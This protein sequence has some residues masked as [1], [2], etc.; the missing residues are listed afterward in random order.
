MTTRIFSSILVLAAG[1]FSASALQAQNCS[2]N[3]VWACRYDQCG[4]QEC[5]CV[6]V[7]QAA[8]WTA[9]QPQCGHFNPNWAD[10]FRTGQEMQNGAAL[11]AYPNPVSGSATISFTLEQSQHVTFRVFDMKGSLVATPADNIFEAGANELTWSTGNI[12]SGVYFLHFQSAETQERIKLVV[13][14]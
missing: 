12:N 6:N 1:I 9:T 7:N 2:S 3:K 11:H 14:N 5:K 4:F 10:G 13:T 8:I